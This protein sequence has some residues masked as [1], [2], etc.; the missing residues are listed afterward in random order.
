MK[1]YQKI[2]FIV[3]CLNLLWATIIYGQPANKYVKDAVMPTPNAAALGKYGDIPVS[4]FTGVPNISIPIYTV[5]DGALSLPIALSYHASGV[6]VGEMASW[7]GMG[8]SLNAGGMI[9]RTV[10]GIPDEVYE[11]GYYAVGTKLE[12]TSFSQISTQTTL[13]VANGFKDSEPDIFS[14]NIN[15]Y[16]GKFYIDAAHKPILVPLQDIKIDFS[17]DFADFTLTTPD[18][19]RFI[20]GKINRNNTNVYAVDKTIGSG[21]DGSKKYISSWH[22]LQVQSFDKTS[23]INLD[24]VP[25]LYRYFNSRT[26]KYRHY[27]YGFSKGLETVNGVQ[28]FAGTSNGFEIGNPF[29]TIIEGQ[30]LSKI[31]TNT[32]TIDFI[33]G[34]IRQDLEQTSND[35]TAPKQLGKIKITT[36][37][38]CSQFE[39]MY[40]YFQ[41]NALVVA[42][43][44]AQDY[45]KLRLKQIQE[46]SCD[47]NALTTKAPHVFTY[48]GDFIANRMSKAI[49]H[50][51]YHN[52]QIANES[53]AVNIPSTTITG[54][55]GTTTV[56]LTHGSSNREANEVEMQKGALTTIKY[57]TGGNTSFKYEAHSFNGF[58]YGNNNTTRLTLNSCKNTIYSCCGEQTNTSQSTPMFFNADELS[59]NITSRATLQLSRAK[60]ATTTNQNANGCAPAYQANTILSAYCSDGTFMGAVSINEDIQPDYEMMSLTLAYLANA[61]NGGFE[62]GKS[63]YFT[64]YSKDV[65]A[66]LK[67]LGAISNEVEVTTIVGGLRIKEIR[68]HDGIN[69]ANDIIKTYDYSQINTTKSSGILFKKPLY[70]FASAGG[71]ELYP[72]DLTTFNDPSKFI[73]SGS[74]ITFN[75]EPIVPLINF[76][77]Y[78][79]GYQC[80]REML[81]GN[82]TSIYTYNV[83]APQAV[84][85]Y[86]SVPDGPHPA[87]GQ[88]QKEIK[89]DNNYVVKAT[90]LNNVA[91][92]LP[93]YSRVSQVMF[94]QISVPITM[95]EAAG[96][97]FVF[98]KRYNLFS[99]AY[100]LASKIQTIDNVTTTTD[101]SYL[102]DYKI[103]LFPT[104]TTITNSNGKTYTTETKYSIENSDAV[105]VEMKNRNI[106][107]PIQTIQKT[108][109]LQTG[110]SRTNY[111]FFDVSGNPTT[112]NGTG[113]NPY[114]ATFQNYKMTY[115]G[116]NVAQTGVWETDGTINK[117]D[118]TIG[119]PTEFTIAN[120]TTPEKYT[121]NTTNK[122]IATKTFDKFTW[123]YEY[124]DN[125]RLVK[126]ITDIDGQFAEFKYDPLMRLLK[127]TARGGKVQTEYTYGYKG[128]AGATNNFVGT[129]T[130]FTPTSGSDLN[131]KEARQYFDGLGRVMQTVGVQQSPNKKDI[132][133]AVTYDNQGRVVQEFMPYESTNTTGAFVTV[134]AT[135][136]FTRKEYEPS[137]LNRIWKVTPP[138]WYATTYEYGGNTT[139]DAVKN[140]TLTR[141]ASLFDVN[142]L[143]K[144][145]ITD[146][147]TNKSIVFK[148]KLGRVVLS[149]KTDNAEDR[150]KNAD[151]YTLYD[152]KSRVAVVIPPDVDYSNSANDGLLFTYA[153]DNEDK[154][155]TKKV[156]D[157]ALV[158]TRYNNRDLP[159]LM[160]VPHLGKIMGTQYDLYGRPT[161]TGFVS[162]NN[163]NAI[164]PNTFTIAD[165]DVL[166]NTA[167]DGKGI[168]GSI[169]YSTDIYKG[170]PTQGEARIMGTNEFMRTNTKYDEYGR[171]YE[172]TGNNHLNRGNKS[173]ETI[174]KVFDFADNVITETRTHTGYATVAAAHRWSYD[175]WG[176]KNAYFL[177]TDNTGEK[178]QAEYKYTE[179][180]LLKELNLGKVGNYTFLQSVDYTYNAQNW[181]EGINA[182]NT[183]SVGAENDL[184][185]LSLR[186]DAPQQVTTNFPATTR[187]NG[188]ISQLQWRVGSQT[189]QV[190]GFEYDYLN[191]LTNAVDATTTGA[192]VGR[193]QE[194]IG[195][196][197]KRGNIKTIFRNGAS[198]TNNVLTTGVIDNLTFNYFPNK[199]TLQAVTEAEAGA[200]AAKGFN[201]GN[202]GTGYTYDASGN[203]TSDTYK[204]ITIQYNHLN[205]PEKVTKGSETI[206]WLYDATGTKLQKKTTTNTNSVGSLI[207]LTVND[208]P[209]PS[210]LY[211]ATTITSTGKVTANSNVTFN[212]TQSIE[213]TAGFE[214]VPSFF[215]EIVPILPS[216]TTTQDYTGGIEYKNNVL[217]AMYHAEGRVYRN[218]NTW[219]YEYTLRDHL[220]NARVTF[221]EASIASF[222]GTS[223]V[224]EILQEN[225]YYPFGMNQE[226]KWASTPNNYQYNG[227]EHINDL[228]LMNI[229]YAARFYNPAL[230]RFTSVDMLAEAN[231]FFNP[232][233]FAAHNPISNVDFM[234]LTDISSNGGGGGGKDDNMLPTIVVTAK[235]INKNL[236]RA[237]TFLDVAG[238][239]PVAQTAAGLIN[240]G[241]DTYRGNY[242]SAAINVASSIPFAGYVV[243]AVK[244]ISPLLKVK[245]FKG[246]LA[247]T[248]MVT[249][250]RIMNARFIHIFD[251]PKHDFSSFLAK[252][253]TQEDAF[254][255]IQKAADEALA[256]GKLTPD[257]RNVL[258]K[259]DLGNI[260]DVD[261][262]DVRL[263][264][265]FISDGK[266]V[267][268]S[269]S[270]YGL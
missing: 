263:I 247:S 9:T 66:S 39:C 253:E 127:T 6:K 123:K 58:L 133:I 192:N 270:R 30:Q 43:T 196:A 197:D 33:Q 11:K 261:G 20:F 264:G 105:S 2:K 170:K 124:E 19:S 156:P 55:I 166:T 130:T 150:L 195:Y 137:P 246:V 59:N 118:P 239:V 243:K 199:N 201:K 171:P 93:T 143:M 97:Y 229:G 184:F 128:I 144:T 122:L 81:N 12:E 63:Y 125:T 227:I 211:A 233:T 174:V 164:D 209:I 165:A 21:E 231:E 52:G 112:A 238:F 103:H 79:V 232:Y 215:A 172:M 169:Q 34:A 119:Y 83:N 31:Y 87:T 230:A 245:A 42:G 187:K 210:K 254:N 212:A 224:L 15:G 110:G 167:Y 53:N 179:R 226:G 200:L 121:W 235:R 44:T 153:Y 214:A 149:R 252:Y 198:V 61:G 160:T 182:E 28:A 90:T 26:A 251:K 18:G 189:P 152:D 67:I 3:C 135:H 109:T 62:V 23:I 117:I 140:C 194:K 77:G 255:A 159:A 176:R 96:R 136:D 1:T 141:S 250:G 71:A 269:L 75:N 178:Q 95:G 236:D 162:G 64:L 111:S 51:G 16:S 262:M 92:G 228:G 132:A 242:G 116:S 218:N 50:W 148:D 45:K 191:R 72:G 80:V 49:D 240:A 222:T 216:T 142:S 157:A 84:S 180:D 7:V 88:I 188:D 101:Y 205:L 202:A 256:N 126:K 91:T 219:R 104:A 35:I 25:E 74:I 17:T 46:K 147:N 76:D 265:G 68:T 204:G 185:S 129:K 260:I 5:Q 106:I 190:Y 48:N 193:Y 69:T 8:W 107:V 181:L 206:A 268:S 29:A 183:T 146:P 131:T 22:L 225:H 60:I 138:K 108:G 186:Y 78:H 14:F 175:H 154:L 94:K 158:D 163:I 32:S 203:M 257:A 208:N 134:P 221:T 40:D 258:P 161:K 113:F 65:Y 13:D 99:Q 120:W 177:N 56:T 37:T 10:Q 223:A 155:L 82:G 86:P 85:V 248:F 168:D 102:Q 57:P 98:Q 173:A 207:N 38:Y 217:E 54:K 41:D 213:M 47:G 220:G 145:T 249:N 234:G 244:I 237:Q 100:R 267:I 151:T 73:G 4:Y 70:A 89:L 266:V 114:P 259:G 24:Y 241:I 36:G 115:N 139:A 27:E